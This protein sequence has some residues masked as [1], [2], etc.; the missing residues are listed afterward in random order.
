M[1]ALLFGHDEAVAGWVA[2]IAKSK[3][4][5]P[6]YTTIGFV[7][8]T[9]RLQGGFV[10]TGFNGNAIEMS[11]AGGAI[12]TRGAWRALLSYVFDQL[13]CSRLQMHTRRNNKRVKRM[14]APN[15]KTNIAFEGVSRRLYGREDGIRYSL[16][17]DDLPA[18]K[19]RW[20]I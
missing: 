12:T 14:L 15:R 7:D 9:G 13:Q 2:K 20:K 10:F 17:V 6:P 16:T 19:A 18:F 1:T 8:D 11:G 4:F 3:P 5:T